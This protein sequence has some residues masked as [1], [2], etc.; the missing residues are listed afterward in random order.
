MEWRAISRGLATHLVAGCGPVSL[1]ALE[2]LSS[3][4]IDVTT[5]AKVNPVQLSGEDLAS[6]KKVIALKETE[7]R[8]MLESQFPDWDGPVD[9]WHVH[10]LDMASPEVALGEV[11]SLVCALVDE[12]DTVASGESPG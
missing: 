4:K 7:H 6:A 1:H 8:P 10:D 5:M 11:K 3:L 9:Y 2:A 12:L